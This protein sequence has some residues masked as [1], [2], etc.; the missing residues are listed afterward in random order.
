MSEVIKITHLTKNY[1]TDAG[2]VCV[3]K[4]VDITINSGEFVAIMGPSG[5]GKSTFMNIITGKLSY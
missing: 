2:E 5:S 3:L 4:G 1:Y